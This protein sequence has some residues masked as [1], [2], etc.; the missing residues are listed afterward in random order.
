MA[1]A[2][3]NGS[4][5]ALLE[6]AVAEDAGDTS[7]EKSPEVVVLEPLNAERVPITR[8]AMSRAASPSPATGADSPV[9]AP[10]IPTRD[11]RSPLARAARVDL[12][13]PLGASRRRLPSIL[14]GAQIA[15]LVIMF[16]LIVVGLGITDASVETTNLTSVLVWNVWWPF[17]VITAF[18]AAR[19]WCT[20]CHLRTIAGWFDRFGLKVKVP[21]ILKRYGTTI[22]VASIVGIFV[23]HSIVVSYGLDHVPSFTAIFLAG[24]M[25]YAAG[26]GLV[27]EK[28]AFCKYFC[29]LVGVMGNYTRV[30][31]TELRSADLE[32]CKRCKDKGCIKNCQNKLYMGTMDDEQQE[33]CLLCMRC[34]KHCP[35]D[36][37]RFSPRPY[38]RGLWQSP[39]RTLSGTFAVLVLLGVVMGEVGEGWAV[40]DGWLLAVPTRIA[41]L[42]GFERILPATITSGGFGQGYLIWESGWVFVLL[43]LII[44]AVCG[45]V[46]F[47]L[48]RKHSPLEHVQIYALGLVPL[49]LSLHAAKLV[50]AFNEAVLGVPHA[51][52]DPRG[53]ATADAIAAGALAAPGALVRPDLWGWLM[54]A[55]VAGLGLLGSLYAVGRIAQVSFEGERGAAVKS[56][57]PFA[58][59]VAALGAVAVLTMYSWLVVGGG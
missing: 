51:I 7:S 16:V 46:A 24:L 58:V 41:E 23:V 15:N 11:V 40:V 45:V 59:A 26:I 54:I 52:A 56:A 8:R 47:L 21:R 37:I 6:T 30:S 19:L 57:I 36:N 22:P 5:E 10:R 3:V 33:S 25:V 50:T 18:F 49:I 13:A 29:P 34:V 14:F 32:Q 31:P 48:V 9:S 20:M 28:N 55:L 4:A 27:F 43:P 1:E 17:I 38:L 2:V 44:L 12:L 35:H 42:T 53:F 39:K